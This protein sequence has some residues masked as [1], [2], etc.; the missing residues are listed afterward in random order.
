ME[1]QVERILA[2]PGIYI[3]NRCVDLCQEILNEEPIA[4]TTPK[5]GQLSALRA[6]IRRL[7]GLL[8][9]ESR[10]V[11]D[12]RAESERLKAKPPAPRRRA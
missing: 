8:R 2:G 12:L 11:K 10:L 4:G 5:G 7:N 6:E 9:L 3:C 1:P